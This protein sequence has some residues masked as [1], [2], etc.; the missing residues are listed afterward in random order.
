MLCPGEVATRIADAGRNRPSGS[1]HRS[2]EVEQGFYASASE[3]VA[4]GLDPAEVAALVV[5]AVRENRFWIL[6]HPE[7]KKI[8]GRRLEA[9]V[10][11]D[12][13]PPRYP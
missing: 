7:W 13:L 8:L 4:K 11:R 1:D 5:D 6:T 2:S 12:A 10:E 9:L 3:I